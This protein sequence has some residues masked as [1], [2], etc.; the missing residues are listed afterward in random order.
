MAP[1]SPYS[2]YKYIY[3]YIHV[4]IYI[5]I[6]PD[7]SQSVFS[8]V[9]RRLTW[10]RERERERERAAIFG[11][12][13]EQGLLYWGPTDCMTVAG[14]PTPPPPPQN[15]MMSQMRKGH[16]SKQGVWQNTRPVAVGHSFVFPKRSRL[17]ILPGQNRRCHVLLSGTWAEHHSSR[18]FRAPT[19]PPP[20][21][22]LP[23]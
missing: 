19:P 1:H 21:Y 7:I 15:P 12:S 6:Y 8:I 20:L 5:Y 2:V 23:R 18:F 9:A 14:F 16:S 11:T 10:E 4:Y 17:L 3:I 13:R 22:L